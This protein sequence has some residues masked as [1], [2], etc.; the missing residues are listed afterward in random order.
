MSSVT[1]VPSTVK[2]PGHVTV[3]ETGREFWAVA[4]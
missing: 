3:T 4:Q 2:A 1:R